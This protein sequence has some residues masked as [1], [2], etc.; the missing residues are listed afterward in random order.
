KDPYTWGH[1]ERVGRIAVRIGKQMALPPAVVSDL[2]LAGLLHDVGKIGIRDSVLQK[3][4]K[5]NA[6]EFEHVKQHP[7]IGDRLVSH[8]R[9]LPP[10]RSGVRNHHERW[11]GT[12]YP[13]GLAGEA[14]PLQARII[15]VADACDAMTSARPYRP[16]MAPERIDSVM[17]EGAGLQWDPDV[18]AQ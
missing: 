18:V 11:D 9:S 15:A 13:D 14:I 1:S 4:G 5:L 8:V 7:L 17:A 2:Y 10:L 12:G 3:Q 16:G 6:E